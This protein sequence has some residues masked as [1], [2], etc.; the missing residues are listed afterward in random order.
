M[1]KNFYTV[2]ET[3]KILHV[4]THTV[5]RHVNSGSIPHKRIGRKILIPSSY[6]K[7]T[8]DKVTLLKEYIFQ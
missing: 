7:I 8:K 4:C 5:Y 1:N 2:E 3:A 6:F